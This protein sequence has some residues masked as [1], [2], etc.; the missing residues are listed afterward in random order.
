MEPL[1][2]K[3]S[4]WLV[5]VAAASL[6]LYLWLA[7]RYP[8]V[9]SLSHPR[10]SWVSLVSPTV[11]NLAAHLAVYLCLT[12]LYLAALWLLFPRAEATS[13][14]SRRL[15][16]FIFAAWLAG[17]VVLLFTSPAGESH[18]IFDYLFRGRMMVEYDANP[19]ADVPD[20]FSITT[21][22][23]RYIA[24]RD[25][26]DTYG[27]LWEGASAA[28][29]AGVRLAASAAGWWNPSAPACPA[30]PQS[31]R[32]LVIYV[33][34]YR[35]LAIL[36]VGLAGG[37]IGGIV[38]RNQPSFTA[39][40]M[41]AWLWNP[42]TLIASALGAHN[43][44][45]MLALVFLSWWLLQRRQLF[46]SLLVLILAAH[47]KLTA[48]I[49]L[50]TCFL[51]I[52]WRYGWRKALAAGLLAAASG[53]AL[54]WLLYAPFGGWGSLPRMLY[55]R[56]TYFANSPWRILFTLLMRT[57]GW[58]GE[59][60]L[61]LTTRL[62]TWLAVGAT[63]FIP[64][65]VFNY[66]PWRRRGQPLDPLEAEQTLWRALAAVSLVFIFVGSF[67]FQHWYILWGLAPV[68][69]LPAGFLARS[70]LPWL[71]LAA[72]SSN[73]FMDFYLSMTHQFITP[74]K[75]YALPVLIIWGT[76]LVLL[77]IRFYTS[78]AASLP[79]G[80]QQTAL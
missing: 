76:L 66:R 21:P 64:L 58:A 53:L 14:P 40:A 23:S 13:A 51:W 79:S 29:S 43:D 33:T 16:V 48:L 10:A 39:L 24:W 67:W 73:V 77:A 57:W 46:G 60:A 41:L 15:V 18:D 27:P 75:K 35:L 9:T 28:V 36:M 2:A 42:L 72:L 5:A 25:N 6:G 20:S 12:L 22:F 1:S 38:G 31:C 17:S 52:L 54:S 30:S 74:L 19:L 70:F 55:E 61:R 44:A 50:P 11:L 69:L 34:A 63:L 8:L 47:V 37:L 62:P 26:V 45:V 32:L 68:V 65:W 80:S 71:A 49:W 56:A 4:G 7:L 59:A 3:R 78:R